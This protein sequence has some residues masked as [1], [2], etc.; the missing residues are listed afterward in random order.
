M[1][2]KIEAVHV[3]GESMTSSM[4]GDEIVVSQKHHCADPDCRGREG[5]LHAVEVKLDNGMSVVIG[6][7]AGGLDEPLQVWIERDGERWPDSTIIRP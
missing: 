6:T 4:A 2:V 1:A 7:D 5:V 3:W